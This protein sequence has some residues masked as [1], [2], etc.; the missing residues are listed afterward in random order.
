M[1]SFD[2][3]INSY[4]MEHCGLH[5]PTSEQHPLMAHTQCDYFAAISFPKVAELGLRVNAL[6]KSS[7]KYE[8]AL[9]EK[10]IEEV[11]AVGGFVHVF[12]DRSTLRPNIKGMND[13][14]RSG[15]QRLLVEKSPSKI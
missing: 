4:L 6:G 10:G 7:V 12:V 13:L 5:P 11:K 8:V 1:C 2:S 9:F 15:L 14:L 3:V